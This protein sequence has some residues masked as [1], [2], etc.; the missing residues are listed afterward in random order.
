[1]GAWGQP[2]WEQ[3]TDGWAQMMNAGPCAYYLMSTHAARVMSKKRR[4]LIVGVTDG[5]VETASGE[6]ADPMG[7]GP[8][9][10]S[11]V[12]PVHQPDDAR[13]GRRSENEEDRHRHADA[14]LH[15][16]RTGRAA[17]DDRR[18]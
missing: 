6:P 1:M 17:P 16:H 15:A 7:M 2:F 8:L 4:G 13:H 18:R 14:G 10:W 5:Y 3:S 12:A 9:L 11:L